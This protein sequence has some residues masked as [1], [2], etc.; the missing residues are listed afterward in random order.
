MLVTNPI[1]FSLV[2]IQILCVLGSCQKQDN[3]PPRIDVNTPLNN[4][5]FQ[6][7]CV[8]QV[9]GDV[10]DDESLY[11]IEISVVDENSLPVTT[12]ISQNISG[13]QFEFNEQFIINDRLLTSGNYFV[14]VNVEDEAENSNSSYTPI[15]ISEVL[16]TSANNTEPTPQGNMAGHGVSVGSS[17]YVS[18]K[19]EEHGYI[20][21]IMSVMPKTAYQQGIPK[22]FKKLDKFDYYWPSFANIGEQPILNEELYHQNNATDAETFGYTPRYAEYKY[23][24]STVHGEFRTS[25]DFWHMGRIFGS[26]PTLNQDFIECNA[27]DVERVFAVTAGQEHLYVYLHNEVKATRLMP[28]FGTPTI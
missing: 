25:L 17:N 8:V 7:P 2:L 18:Y 1:K 20:I 21:G 14:K 5:S 16:Q 3:V 15:T 24:P 22:H 9:E 13:D 19:C 23:I 11:R 26:K 4:T 6:I 12:T 27:D 10:N 28:Y